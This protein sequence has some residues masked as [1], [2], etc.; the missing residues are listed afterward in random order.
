MFI[1]V[2]GIDRA[3]KSTLVKN[4][5]RRFPQSESIHFPVFL[6]P[7]VDS[8][9]MMLME[10]ASFHK[11]IISTS[12]SL[13]FF[14][15]RWMASGYAYSGDRWLLNTRNFLSPDLMLYL[16]L[17]PYDASKRTGF[18]EGAHEDIEFLNQ[19]RTRYEEFFIGIRYPMIRIDATLKEEEVLNRAINSIEIL[20]H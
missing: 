18:G 17:I 10:R 19:V 15:D 20:L 2:E 13:F 8:N 9:F 5:T 3:G 16:D 1:V 7:E 11:E 6:N 14:S 12:P 4:L